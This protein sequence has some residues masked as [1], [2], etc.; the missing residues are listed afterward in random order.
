[1]L[2]FLQQNAGYVVAVFTTIFAIA[3]MQ[4][5]DMRIILVSQIIANGLLGVQAILGGTA[6]TSWIIF[7]AIVQTVISFA[8][9]SKSKDFPIWLTL[10]FA[11]GYTV[12]TVLLFTSPFDILTC[13][14]AWFF[15]LAVVQKDSAVCR[16]Y[17]VVNTALWLVYDIF[18]M[19][20]G[21]VN[22]SVIICFIIFA[23]VRLDRAEWRGGKLFKTMLA[24]FSD[25]IPGKRA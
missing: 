24:S 17:S 2:E 21:I 16:F 8:F 7:L 4:F 5:K 6:S 18:V 13:I 15:A 10:I 1:M 25:L 9:A 19:Q 12:I 22:H 14:A 11:I 3:G 20:T 23:I